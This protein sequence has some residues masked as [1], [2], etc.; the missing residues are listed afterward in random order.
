MKIIAFEGMDKS[1]KHTA[2]DY[3]YDYL[4]E[5]GYNVVKS[6]FHRYDTPTGKLIQDYLYGKYDVSNETI[7]L[8]MSADKQAQQEWFKEL[9]DD[10]VEFLILDRYTLSQKVYSNYFIKKNYQNPLKKTYYKNLYS[11][12]IK[13]FRRPDLT[14]YLDNSS[15]VS[16]QRKGQWGENDKYESDKELLDFVRTEY[17]KLVVLNDNYLIL[18]SEQPIKKVLS[19]LTDNFNIIFKDKILW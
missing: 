11:E 16:M 2:S 1:G 17:L 8:I 6:E 3:L 7:Q 19:D 5:K 12:I 9:E 18:N 15:E 13:G 4:K 14:I 10:G